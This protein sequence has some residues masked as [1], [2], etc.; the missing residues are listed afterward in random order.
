[1]FYFIRSQTIQEK[2]GKKR[3]CMKVIASFISV[4]WKSN[5]KQDQDILHI[6]MLF[7]LV[8]F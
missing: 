3:N 1:M 8:M 2:N 5:L 6:L 4:K 7:R